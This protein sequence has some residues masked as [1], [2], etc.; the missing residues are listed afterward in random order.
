M[1]VR[2][3]S[4][5]NVN[6]ILSKILLGLMFVDPPNCHTHRWLQS[7]R[8][9]GAPKTD[10]KRLS[11]PPSYYDSNFPSDCH[12]SSVFD[13]IFFLQRN[14]FMSIRRSLR[15]VLCQGL[16]LALMIGSSFGRKRIQILWA[17]ATF[18]A[19]LWVMWS[20]LAPRKYAAKVASAMG[21][22]PV[23]V[24]QRL[25]V[26]IGPF[27]HVSQRR[28]VE[29]TPL[30]LLRLLLLTKTLHLLQ[31]NRNLPFTHPLLPRHLRRF[32]P[33]PPIHRWRTS[34]LTPT[35]KCLA[36]SKCFPGILRFR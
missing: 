24:D 18:A 15:R 4:R 1:V 9:M 22:W 10:F 7:L 5:R 8:S 35:H 14:L 26:L 2:I 31:N 23:A 32:L 30:L 33:P 28:R 34:L 13:R 17:G 6:G 19:Y 11:F 16:N 21:I 27:H 20:R 29:L 3:T 36:A 12:R 25:R